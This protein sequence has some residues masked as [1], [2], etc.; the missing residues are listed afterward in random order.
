MPADT[1]RV[2]YWDTS[3]VLSSL[4]TDRHSATARDWIEKTGL[5]LISTLAYAETCAV[6]GRLKTEGHVT[7]T[8][9]RAAF[10]MLNQGPWRFTTAWPEWKTVQSLSIKWPLRGAELWHLA[11]AVSLRN[12]LPE[13]SILTFDRRLQSAVNGEGLVAS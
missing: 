2:L 10:D 1:K 9:I 4:F 13:L 7:D 11:T 3:A 8:L 12:R 6:I 5:H